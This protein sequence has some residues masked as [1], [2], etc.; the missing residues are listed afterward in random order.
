MPNSR[1]KVSRCL[2]ATS[3]FISKTE[4]KTKS[5][6]KPTT[7]QRQTLFQLH[8]SLL[9]GDQ[10]KQDCDEYGPLRNTLQD[11]TISKRKTYDHDLTDKDRMKMIIKENKVDH[12]KAIV[13]DY[14]NIVNN[15]SSAKTSARSYRSDSIGDIMNHTRNVDI[16]KK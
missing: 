16:T 5:D 12:G 6:K 3:K 2:Q 10:L 9:N 8:G 15:K 4:I 13:E 11:T 1:S 14:R 7:K